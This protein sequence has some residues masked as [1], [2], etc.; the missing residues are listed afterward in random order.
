M[1]PGTG[2]AGGRVLFEFRPLGGQVRIA[3]LDE[4]TGLEVVAIAPASATR[5]QMQ[6]LAA[7]KLRRALNR[8][9][10]R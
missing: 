7:A 6:Q 9:A 3:A 1:K 2:P 8:E 4:R 10:G 5:E